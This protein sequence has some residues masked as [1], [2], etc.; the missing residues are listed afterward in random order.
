MSC[1]ILFAY[2]QPFLHLAF[3]WHSTFCLHSTFLENLFTLN[4]FV[5]IQ[6]FVYI[7]RMIL[8]IFSFSVSAL[9]VGYFEF[10]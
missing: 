4:C 10:S 8:A 9:E 2:D 5:D 1:F 3:C 6:L 7:L